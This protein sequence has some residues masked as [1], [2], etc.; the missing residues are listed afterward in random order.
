MFRFSL[1][2][3]DLEGI[4]KTFLNGPELQEHRHNP[5]W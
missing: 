4:S 1:K 5:Y 2:T 3:L